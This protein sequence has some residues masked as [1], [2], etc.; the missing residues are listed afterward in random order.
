MCVDV[1]EHNTSATGA[2]FMS[3]STRLHSTW[4]CCLCMHA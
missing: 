2:S 3:F 1:M 4:V